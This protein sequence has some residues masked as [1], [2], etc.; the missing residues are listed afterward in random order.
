[1]P[2]IRIPRDPKAPST[3][4][5]F[6]RSV[7][8]GHPGAAQKAE[9]IVSELIS[10]AVRHEHSSAALEVTVEPRLDC[11]HIEVSTTA[12]AE[13]CQSTE[14]PPESR[15][16]FGLAIVDSLSRRWGVTKG[17]SPYV[18]CEIALP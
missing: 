12:P 3:G 4:R 17:A 15:P 11:A 7:L 2:R 14:E 9:L 6:V 8:S 1:M 18:W 16:G 13:V 10:N 5:H